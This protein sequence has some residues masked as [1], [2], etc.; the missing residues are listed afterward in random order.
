MKI[1]YLC[2]RKKCNNCSYPMCKH[3]SDINHAKNFKYDGAFVERK[4]ID[5]ECGDCKYRGTKGDEYPC[6]ECYRNY[7][8]RYEEED[9]CS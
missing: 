1:I 6:N 8:D 9:E 7:Y 3:T 5:T 4:T 2:D